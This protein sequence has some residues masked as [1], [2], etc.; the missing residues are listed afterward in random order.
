LKNDVNVLSKSNKQKALGKNILVGAW[1]VTEKR[2]GSGSVSLRYGYVDP[3]L[4]KCHGSGTLFIGLKDPDP[5]AII[6][7]LHILNVIIPNID[8]RNLLI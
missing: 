4:P 7:D 2:P 3:D 8:D 1:K 5:K 6:T